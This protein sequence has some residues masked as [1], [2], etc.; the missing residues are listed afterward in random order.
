[1]RSYRG[2]R[3][4]F[5]TF[6]TVASVTVTELL[7]LLTLLFSFHQ[8]SIYIYFLKNSRSELEGI[9]DLSVTPPRKKVTP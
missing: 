3:W 5:N 8:K 2:Y 9:F 6:V 7:R 1:M 4:L